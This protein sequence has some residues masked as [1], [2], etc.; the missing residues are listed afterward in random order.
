MAMQFFRKLN[1]QFSEYWKYFSSIVVGNGTNIG[2]QS[3]EELRDQFFAQARLVKSMELFSSKG[4]TGLPDNISIHQNDELFYY[5]AIFFLYFKIQPSL[6]LNG[7]VIWQSSDAT[8]TK[9][10]HVKILGCCG[11]QVVSVHALLFWQ[12]EFESCHPWATDKKVL[13][14]SVWVLVCDF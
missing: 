14:L 11:G 4:V 7:E 5:K 12:S 10:L 1:P 9:D 6:L 2:L 3:S 13:W 8:L